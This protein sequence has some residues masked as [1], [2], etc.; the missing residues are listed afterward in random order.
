M[1]TKTRWISPTRTIRKRQG[2]SA[3]RMSHI[4]QNCQRAN[5]LAW[6]AWMKNQNIAAMKINFLKTHRDS[7]IL[8]SRTA[9]KTWQIMWRK[10]I[11]KWQPS[12]LLW[13][14]IF[15]AVTKVRTTEKNYYLGRFSVAC[16][17]VVWSHQLVL[18]NDK[19]SYTDASIAVDK[20][21]GCITCIL[22]A[23]DLYSSCRI[24]KPQLSSEWLGEWLRNHE[25]TT[26]VFFRSWTRYFSSMYFHAFF[27]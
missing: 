7:R 26:L 12:K 9:K 10:R 23:C 6:T 5:G 8:H 19:R 3:V 11:F 25:E 24:N 15:G 2:T 27:D 13:I 22:V 14:W 20:V 1:L 16:Y 17:V 21:N 18:L 4:Y